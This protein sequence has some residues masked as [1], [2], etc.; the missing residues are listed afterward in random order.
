MPLTKST[1]KKAFSKNVKAEVAAGRPIKQAVAIGYAEQKEAKKH[2][3][4]TKIISQ[5]KKETQTLRAI[6]QSYIRT[7]DSL[8]VLN[9][10]LTDE[11]NTIITCSCAAY[12]GK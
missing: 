4:D 3:N 2:K 1:S 11:K 10:T 5:L 9:K 7:I 6:M 12:Y 8:G